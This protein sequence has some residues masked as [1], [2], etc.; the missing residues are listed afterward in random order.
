MICILSFILV[1]CDSKE[2]DTLLI[3]DTSSVMLITKSGTSDFRP[4]ESS[5]K[6][7][8]IKYINKL[9]LTELDDVYAG[10]T[11]RIVY[12]EL[13]MT[14]SSGVNINGVSYSTD[15]DLDDLYLYLTRAYNYVFS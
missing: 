12:R 2:E 3:S 6:E 8:I 10:W 9:E 13:D 11:Y 1:S 5:Y 7:K 4:V 15:N 14:F